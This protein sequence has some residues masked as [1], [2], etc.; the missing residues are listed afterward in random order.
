MRW[1]FFFF[2]ANILNYYF[3]FITASY[4]HT[5]WQQTPSKY[6]K[7]KH[8]QKKNKMK[9]K[10]EKKKPPKPTQSKIPKTKD[11]KTNTTQ[12]ERREGSGKTLWLHFNIWQGPRGRLGRACSGG[13]MVTGP[14]VMVWNQSKIDL[15]WRLGGSYSQLRWQNTGTC[16]LGMQLKPCPCKHTRLESVWPRA[17]WSS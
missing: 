14:G 12:A 8:R 9:P 2:L 15:S 16:C 17:A 1:F 10:Q 5:S 13:L 4:S 6:N 11:K 7:I 3:F